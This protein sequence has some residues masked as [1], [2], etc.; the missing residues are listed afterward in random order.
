MFSRSRNL[1]IIGGTYTDNRVEK[2]LYEVAKVR[3][4]SLLHAIDLQINN[5]YT[6]ID[7]FLEASA[8]SAFHNSGERF[9]PPKCHPRTRIHILTKIMNWVV[10]EVG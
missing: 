7:A 2:H 5:V 8:P 9:D 3:G 6:G 1:L 10:G 4:K